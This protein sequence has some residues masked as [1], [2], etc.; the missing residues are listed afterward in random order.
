M[1]HKTGFRVATRFPNQNRSRIPRLDCY[2]ERMNTRLPVTAV[3][4]LVIANAH[5]GA[6]SEVACSE[7]WYQSVE[8]Q[9]VSGDGQGHG[10]D[11][12]SNE[13]KSVVEFKLGI[14]GQAGLPAR[15]SHE[16]CQYIDD[17]LRER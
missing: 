9:L 4:A 13:W 6:E 12:G 7:T 3:L 17:L 5:A 10:P 8:S 2:N 11:P 1:A 14:R 16:W 15:D